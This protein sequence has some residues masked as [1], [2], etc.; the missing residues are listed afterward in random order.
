[1]KP[2]KVLALAATGVIVVGELSHEPLFH[3]E[4]RGYEA[5]ETMTRRIVVDSSVGSG[6]TGTEAFLSAK[7][8]AFC[9]NDQQY[10]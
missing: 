7:G 9:L 5:P 10:R 1:M 3:V 6:H 2:Y 8:L 4:L